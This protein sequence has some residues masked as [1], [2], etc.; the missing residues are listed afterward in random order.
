MS[1]KTLNFPFSKCFL[2]NI[3]PNLLG[4]V[5][6]VVGAISHLLAGLSSTSFSLLTFDQPGVEGTIRA[7]SA[8]C[9][10][11]SCPTALITLW[12]Q[13]G[14]WNLTLGVSCF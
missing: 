9:N 13:K 7:R 10:R 6:F 11:H 8:S 5:A 3:L 14:L 1:V 4:R 12:R 2:S